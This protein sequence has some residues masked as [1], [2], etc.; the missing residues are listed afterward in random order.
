MLFKQRQ[1]FAIMFFFFQVEFGSILKNEFS[2]LLV[3]IPHSKRERTCNG[4]TEQ[5]GRQARGTNQLTL[6][7]RNAK[8]VDMSTI[9][10]MET[11]VSNK[12]WP[13]FTTYNAINTDQI[14]LTHPSLKRS[15][16]VLIQSY[17][18]TIL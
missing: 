17:C 5:D 10:R 8:E 18:K 12:V 9:E 16:T 3:L 7:M 1:S 11:D 2:K 13:S 15:T 4:N 14:T 6:C